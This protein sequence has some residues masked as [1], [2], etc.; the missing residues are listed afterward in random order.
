MPPPI[1]VQGFC[2]SFPDAHW[3][4]EQCAVSL[5]GRAL[6]PSFLK[7]DITY[8]QR[9]KEPR[10]LVSLERKIQTAVFES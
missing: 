9:T 3:A 8:W 2:A 4:R 1:Q 5:E 6:L 7:D 10:S